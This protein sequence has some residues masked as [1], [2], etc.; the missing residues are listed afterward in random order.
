MISKHQ[1]CSGSHAPA[2]EPIP[3]SIVILPYALPRGSV[4]TRNLNSKELGY[5]A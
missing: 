1:F 4:G 2:W 5:G 3:C